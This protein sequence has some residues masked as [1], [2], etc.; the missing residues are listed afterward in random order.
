M[1]IDNVLPRIAE[2]QKVLNM[3]DFPETALTLKVQQPAGATMILGVSS[4]KPLRALQEVTGGNA[5]RVQVLTH[6]FRKHMTLLACGMSVQ[7]DMR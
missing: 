6:P 4:D 7:M 2:V 1:V 5:N 3:S